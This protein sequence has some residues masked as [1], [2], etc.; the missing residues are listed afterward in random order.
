MLATS[1]KSSIET[2]LDFPFSRNEEVGAERPLIWGADVESAESV[3]RERFT[4]MCES[5]ELFD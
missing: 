4:S 3:E 2:V 1:M 5:D